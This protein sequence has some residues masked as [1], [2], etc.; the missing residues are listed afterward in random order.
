MRYL[1]LVFAIS[2]PVFLKAEVCVECY[3]L[4]LEQTRIINKLKNKGTV[5]DE[6]LL[7][8]IKASEKRNKEKQKEYVV[9]ATFEELMAVREWL[10][11]DAVASFARDLGYGFNSE[12]FK[13]NY[14]VKG[15]D[16]QPRLAIVNF[17][18]ANGSFS[19]YGLDIF[20]KSEAIYSVLLNASVHSAENEF[21]Q[22]FWQTIIDNKLEKY[23]IGENA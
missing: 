15:S 14:P 13:K 2:L 17:A 8:L 18:R 19:V 12:L 20:A 6:K 5:S 7:L 1:A 10:V 9:E 23:I 4:T 11:G 16:G 21:K 22:I 3:N